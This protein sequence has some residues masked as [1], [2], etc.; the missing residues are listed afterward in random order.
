MRIVLIMLI[1]V[2]SSP[3]A[4]APANASAP[5][6]PSAA[7]VSTGGGLQVQST[8]KIFDL[9][10]RSKHLYNFK[11]EVEISG[12]TKKMVATYTDL[13]GKVL[14]YETTILKQADGKEMLVSYDLDHKQ[15]GATGKIEVRDGKAH[16]TYT[17][18]G[19]TKTASEK[20][21]DDFIISTMI[22]GFLGRNWDKIKK[23][24][25]L[26]VRLG[27]VDRRETVGF[28]YKKESESADGVKVKMRPSSMIIAAIVNP[29]VWTMEPGGS[30]LKELEG[31]S[32]VKALENG[33]FKDFDG[34]TVYTQGAQ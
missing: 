32:P 27:V 26:K 14:V 19:E 1:G 8:A 2:L 12:D 20:V 4:F 18:D 15:M 5:V 31:R 11:N 10:D 34:Y 25:S 24:E 30:F 29:L 23:G 6:A 7:S 17:K 3:F 13:D 22:V 33:K 28:S 16:F 21:G 9:K